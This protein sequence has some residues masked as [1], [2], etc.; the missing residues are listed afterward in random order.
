MDASC[1]VARVRC[2]YAYFARLASVRRSGH[3]DPIPRVSG[4]LARLLFGWLQCT[5]LAFSALLANR[6][7]DRTDI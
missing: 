6:T 1:S 3:A 7:K 5:A 2:G 4:L